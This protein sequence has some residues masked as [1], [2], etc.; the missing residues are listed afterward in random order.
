MF[1][2]AGLYVIYFRETAIHNDPNEKFEYASGHGSMIWK[3]S[4]ERTA[5]SQV[6]YHCSAI[7]I[8]NLL[9]DSKP[10]V[11]SL[12]DCPKILGPL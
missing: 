6:W 9:P 12:T 7:F 11:T 5:H 3:V 4:L 1:K 8:K 10:H 2:K